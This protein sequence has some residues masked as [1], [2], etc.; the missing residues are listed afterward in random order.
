MLFGLQAQ[1]DFTVENEQ[2]IAK[3]RR[4]FGTKIS[5]QSFLL[6]R[7]CVQP[8]G[9]CRPASYGA[10]R[11]TDRH[12]HQRA[13]GRAGAQ[14]EEF[15]LPRRSDRRADVPS[16]PPS[17]SSSL[18]CASS[19]SGSWAQ[20]GRRRPLLIVA[21][22]RPGAAASRWA[23]SGGALNDAVAKRIVSTHRPRFATAI[24]TWRQRRR[25]RHD[26]RIERACLRREKGTLEGGN[27]G[28]ACLL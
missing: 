23:T 7:F 13:E 8:V 5:D 16:R 6:F 9:S 28:Q 19:S 1:A 15:E 10:G 26:G 18:R 22:E 4:K 3:R 24:S 12:A 14:A 21:K 11:R 20:E 2:E 17:R 25:G 27:V